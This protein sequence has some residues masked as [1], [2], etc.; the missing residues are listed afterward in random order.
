[1]GCPP[2]QVAAQLAVHLTLAVK[3]P[4][5]IVPGREH[6]AGHARAEHPLAA[7]EEKGRVLVLDTIFELWLSWYDDDTICRR[8]RLHAKQVARA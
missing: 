2:T 7:G 3:E 5:A 8:M 4:K 6:D 1:V